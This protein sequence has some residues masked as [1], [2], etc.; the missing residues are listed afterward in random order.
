MNLIRDSQGGRD[1]TECV[2][3]ACS[4][5]PCSNGGTCMSEAAEFICICPL[6]FGG[7]TCNSTSKLRFLLFML[8]Q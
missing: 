7:A 2:N 5:V 4:S 1:I 3:D 6:G 8:L